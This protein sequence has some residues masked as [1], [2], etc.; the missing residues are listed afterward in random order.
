MNFAS[1]T[2][3]DL[4]GL[5]ALEDFTPVYEQ[6]DQIRREAKGKIGRAS[7]RERV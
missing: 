6:A 5:L 2:K 4:A 7:C 3:E 1:L